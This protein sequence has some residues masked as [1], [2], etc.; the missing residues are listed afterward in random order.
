MADKHTCHWPR[1]GREI[2]RGHWACPN[3]WWLIPLGLRT[4]VNRAWRAYCAASAEHEPAVKLEQLRV[5]REAEQ[6]VI[7][8]IATKYPT[9]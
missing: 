7:D 8:W 5:Y 2:R 9:S 6:A 1:C 3:H 4:R